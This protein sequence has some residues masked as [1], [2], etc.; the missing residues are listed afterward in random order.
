MLHLPPSS[1]GRWQTNIGGMDVVRSFDQRLVDRLDSLSPAEQ[2]VAQ[3]FRDNREEVLIAS[4][5]SLAAKID[6]S[7]ATVVRATKALG[8]AGLEELRRNLAAELRASL[9]L[10]DRL[11]RT[12][13]EVGESL[14]S[15]FEA[16]LA[17]QIASLERLHQ[18]I[19]TELFERAIDEITLS[20]RIAVFGIG[21]SGA[22]AEYLAIQL[23]RFGFEALT[24][25]RTG[26]LFADDLQKVREGD[27][28]II[29]AYDHVYIELSV[30]LDV[31]GQRGL[32]SLLVT[33]TL[34]V[35][36]RHR[37]DLVLPVSRGKTGM[38]SMHTATLGLIETLLVGI[39]SQRPQETLAN[40]AELN[41]MREKLAGKAA[42]L[43]ISRKPS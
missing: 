25:S 30:L 1:R 35:T 29:F 18:S 10:A 14:S 39:A 37:V 16:T 31:I 43:S 24:L 11:E 22:L 28:V 40:L 4:A 34:A 12:L 2:R 36:L 21:P 41:E 3:F 13:G 32:R 20:R 7:D 23:A 15:A 5:A 33:D 38:L 19:P 6:T 17:I 9:S 27:L 26:L 8:Y 42:G